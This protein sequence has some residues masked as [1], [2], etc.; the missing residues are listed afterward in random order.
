MTRHQRERRRAM[1]STAIGLAILI[2]VLVIL[3]AVGGWITAEQPI[4]T[5]QR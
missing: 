5:Y 3:P 2:T 4:S 1:A